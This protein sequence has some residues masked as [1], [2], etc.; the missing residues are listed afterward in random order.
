MSLSGQFPSEIFHRADLLIYS[1]IFT[2]ESSAVTGKEIMLKKTFMQKKHLF[3][4]LDDNLT[5][6]LVQNIQ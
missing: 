1:Y 4:S 2:T 6:K 3:S 5:Y